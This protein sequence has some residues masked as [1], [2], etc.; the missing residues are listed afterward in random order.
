AADAL[1]DKVAELRRKAAI[2]PAPDA[3]SLTHYGLSQPRARVVLTLDDGKVETLALGDES[4]FDGSVFVRTTSGAVELVTG[5]AKWSLERTTFDLREKRLLPFDDEELRRVEVTAPRLSYALVRDGKTWRL[6]APAKERADDA[7]AARVLGAIRGLRATAFLGSPQGDRAHGLEK[8]RWKVRLVAASGAPRTLLLG[9][10]P[11]PPSRPP[12]SPASPPRDQTGTSSLYAKIEG[13]REVAVLPDGA[14]KDLDV[15]LFALRDKTVMHFDREKVAAA[16][17]TVGSSSFEG[18]VDAKQE[19]GGRRLASLL[20]TLSSLKAKAF[21]DESG[22]TL[23]EH[24]LDHPAYQVALLDQG[25]KELD[26]LLVS[27][28]RGGKTFARALSSPRIV[29]ID[30]AALASLPKSADELQEKPPLKAEAAP[31]IR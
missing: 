6:D 30:P 12:S 31:G 11:R 4:S 19:E 18:K 7:T 10:A 2:A 27:A 3:A 24:G 16:K 17:F 25:G 29:E 21:A 28:D 8:P 22:R 15:D 23:A 1:V 14:A 20:W 13:A 26:R 9:E 5:D